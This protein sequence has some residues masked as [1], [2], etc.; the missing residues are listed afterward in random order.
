VYRAGPY[1]DSNQ[2]LFPKERS[3]ELSRL[4]WCS[5]GADEIEI[6]DLLDGM[7]EN[8]PIFSNRWTEWTTFS[9]KNSKF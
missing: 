2:D 3:L 4:S 5:L 1:E 7:D 8:R 9:P 6:M